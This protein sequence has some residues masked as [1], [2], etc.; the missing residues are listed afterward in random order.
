MLLKCGET[1]RDKYRSKY[2]PFKVVLVRKQLRLKMK[3]ITD[4]FKLT[5][6]HFRN[7]F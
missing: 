6:V 5:C 3:S 2:N 4:S 1:L 7:T